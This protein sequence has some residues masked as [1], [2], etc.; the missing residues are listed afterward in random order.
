MTNR[1]IETWAWVLLY[2]GLM[3]GILGLFV[4]RSGE[5]AGAWLMIA[6]GAGAAAGGVMVW[7]RSRR[8]E[9]S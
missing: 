7:W 8:K 9:G 6:G 4:Q 2:G 5:P 1:A 3:V